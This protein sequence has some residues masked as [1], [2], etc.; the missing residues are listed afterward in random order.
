MFASQASEPPSFVDCFFW[1]NHTNKPRLQEAENRAKA[2]LDRIG[3]AD[4]RERQARAL[5]YGQR[6]LLAALALYM[7][8]GSIAVCDEPTAGLD[9]K[10]AKTVFNLLLDW[11]TEDAQ[12][13]IIVATH[14]LEYVGLQATRLLRMERG[15]LKGNNE[16]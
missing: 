10:R 7:N 1:K 12:R 9:E 15:I 5:S 16:R 8:S 14:D 13:A 6:K 4:Y 2:I 3:W 11:K